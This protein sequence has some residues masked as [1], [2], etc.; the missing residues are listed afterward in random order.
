MIC[1]DQEYVSQL[2]ND[3]DFFFLIT[4]HNSIVFH[5]CHNFCLADIQNIAILIIYTSM[6]CINLLA[7][8][9]Y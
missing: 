7:I 1:C 3:A 9:T 5:L 4:N 8:S 6:I 2:G